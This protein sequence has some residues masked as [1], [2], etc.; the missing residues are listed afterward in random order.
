[1]TK[2]IAFSGRL[3]SGKTTATNFLFGLEMLRIDNPK[4]IDCFSINNEGKLMVPAE[5]PDGIKPAVFDPITPNPNT[6]EYLSIN[7][8]PYIK[9]YNFADS[10]KQDICINLL[11]LEWNQCYGSDAEK[12][13]LT[14]LKWENM[15][16]VITTKVAYNK[17]K[18]CDNIYYHESGLM[19]AREVMQFVGTKLFRRMYGQIWVDACIRKIKYEQ[20]EIAVI[21]DCR[22]P[23]EV[24]SIK[25]AGGYVIRLTREAGNQN[26]DESETALDDNVF[27]WKNFDAVID[28]KNMTI[29]EQNNATLEVLNNLGVIENKVS[30]HEGQYS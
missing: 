16:G 19:T 15:P 6:I 24:L 30:E 12:N 4:L 2:I 11:G 14:K 27:S 7:I 22:F 18:S 8:W 25:E 28:N 13:S 10:L 21:G 20:P 23:N 29:E 9:Q 17:V 26:N 1:M 5:F 3:Q